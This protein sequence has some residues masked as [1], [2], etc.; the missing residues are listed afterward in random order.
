V[1]PRKK[2]WRSAGTSANPDAPSEMIQSKRMI[3]SFK[4]C[5]EVWIQR[6]FK[7]A[8]S[9]RSGPFLNNSFTEFFR[10]TDLKDLPKKFKFLLTWN[11]SRILDQEL[12]EG[13]TEWEFPLMGM[14]HRNVRNSVLS[15]ITKRSTKQKVA[16][17]NLLQCKSLAADVS[18]EFI[19]E[20]LKKHHKTLSK[21][22]EDL[23]PSLVEEFR[24]F[25]QPWIKSVL[26]NYTGTTSYP[27]NHSTASHKRS[28]GGLKGALIEYEHIL[29]AQKS[30]LGF[31]PRKEPIVLTLDGPPGSGKS[32]MVKKIVATICKSFNCP[33]TS[34]YYRSSATDHW[35]GYW[36]QPITVLDDIGAFASGNLQP[37]EDLKELL[38]LVSEC[39]YIVPMADLSDKGQ[40][41]VSEILIITTNNAAR[42]SD[43]TM[44]FSCPAAVQ[45]RFG[46]VVRVVKGSLF[47]TQLQQGPHVDDREFNHP[48]NGSRR[49]LGKPTDVQSVVNRLKVQYDEFHGILRQPLRGFNAELAFKKCDLSDKPNAVSVTGIV[50]PLKVRTITRPQYLT[51]A[52]KP[53]QE[54]MFTALRNWKC[55]TPCWDPSYSLQALL[56]PVEGELL[57]SGDY[58]SA[59][60]DLNPRIQTVVAEELV[61]MFGP[62]FLSDLITWESGPHIVSYPRNTDLEDILQTNGQLMGSLLSFPILCLAN[63]FTLCRA[64]GTTLSTVRG[65]FHG[66]DIA[67]IVDQDSYDSWKKS[68]GEIGLSLSVGKNYLS[69]D[70]VSI[71]S[72]LFTWSNGELIHQQTGKFRLIARDTN[73]LNCKTSLEQ[74][75]SKDLI[76][77]YCSKTLKGSLRS[78]DVS[79]EEGGLGLVTTRPLTIIDRCIYRVM[80]NS[81]TRCS[82]VGDLVRVPKEL[83]Q[84]LRLKKAETQSLPEEVQSESNLNKKVWRLLAQANKNPRLMSALR[85]DTLRPLSSFRS[86]LVRCDQTPSELNSMYSHF[87]ERETR[88]VFAT[89]QLRVGEDV[90]GP[91]RINRDLVLRR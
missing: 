23:S 8:D 26:R 49:I 84:I 14:I 67:A 85:V 56:E 44:G 80:R 70:F 1:L 40:K 66:D 38:Q 57:L 87:Y 33:E 39:D 64:T 58:T 47:E 72:Q 76:R 19:Q 43:F 65:V 37:S 28:E 69:K 6:S 25:I 46:Q 53:L 36:G 82:P 31:R 24:E 90:T 29:G 89:R 35:D 77:K 7:I 2:T 75:F 42:G 81:K 4:T 60:D 41:F 9:R 52:L 55:F 61:K 21:I 51:Y 12:P 74:G 20:A 86:C 48:L 17:W 78:L 83:A 54:A 45:R 30:K 22:P 10:N 68:A 59:T 62:G 63:A 3:H 71:D 15:C 27:T 11:F 5:L 73:E 34:V 79:Y 16:L 32:T 91:K 18:P 13:P 50:E 88:P